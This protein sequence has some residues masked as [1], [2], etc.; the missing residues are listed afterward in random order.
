MRYLQLG[1]FIFLLT[2]LAGCSQESAVSPE[3]TPTPVP[4]PLIITY[5]DIETSDLCLKG[6]GQEDEEHMLILFFADDRS[7]ADIYVLTAYEGDELRF[8]C[9]QSQN[10]L[11]NVYCLG[12]A[13][14]AGES[15]KLNIHANHDDTLIAQGVFVVQYGSFPAPDVTFD[16][17]PTPS[18][19][20]TSTPAKASTPNS[21]SAPTTT[22]SPDHPTQTINPSYPNYPNSTATP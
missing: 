13:F 4:P 21:V 22:Q 19:T 6:F 14:L 11:E 1:L 9:K 3:V 15:V 5:C 20:S 18:A 16:T 17:I 10:F 2:L 7:F 8:E 12:D